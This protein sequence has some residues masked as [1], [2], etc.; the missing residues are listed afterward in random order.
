MVSLSPTVGCCKAVV[1]AVAS[2][3]VAEEAG[4]S[5]VVE[6]PVSSCRET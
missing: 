5:M 3:A 2:R 4:A 6:A 1:G